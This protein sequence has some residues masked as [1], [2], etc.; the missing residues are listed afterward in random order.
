MIVLFVL[1]GLIVLIAILIYCII[2]LERGAWDEPK[3]NLGEKAKNKK[4]RDED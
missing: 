1:S 2:Q 4:V 3:Q